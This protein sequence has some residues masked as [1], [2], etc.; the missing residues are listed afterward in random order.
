MKRGLPASV[1]THGD[2]PDQRQPNPTRQTHRAYTG[3]IGLGMTQADP[4]MK[5]VSSA[6]RAIDP[7]RFFVS[8]AARPLVPASTT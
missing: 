3:R 6:V 4:P 1:N 2:K 8:R 7:E 5:P